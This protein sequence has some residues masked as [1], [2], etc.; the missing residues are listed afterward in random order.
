MAELAV[1]DAIARRDDVAV[2]GDLE[3]QRGQVFPLRDAQRGILRGERQ[4]EERVAVATVEGPDGVW[5]IEPIA[6][7]AFVVAG[8][9]HLPTG[10]IAGPRAL[11][12]LFVPRATHADRSARNDQHP[13]PTRLP[14]HLAI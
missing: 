4:L 9:A 3:L 14:L 1:L 6:A 8:I 7:V 11:A 2:I 5:V 13:N 10:I 12:A